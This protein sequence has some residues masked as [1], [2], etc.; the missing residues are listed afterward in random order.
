MGVQCVRGEWNITDGD[1]PTA[2]DCAEAVVCNVG[3]VKYP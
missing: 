3:E 2:E 1:M